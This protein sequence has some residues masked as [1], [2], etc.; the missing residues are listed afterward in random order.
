MRWT[1]RCATTKRTGADGKIVWSWPPDAE[2]KFVDDDRRATVAIKPGHRGERVISRRAIAQG[3]PWCCG[4]PVVSTLVCFAYTRGCGCFGHPA[5]PA[6]SFSRGTPMT[7]S[8]GISCRE[9]AD[10]RCND[11]CLNSNRNRRVGKAQACPP[12]Q[13]HAVDTRWAR[14]KRAFAHPTSFL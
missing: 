10:A 11:G 6:P 3:M 2:V 12:V 9:N 4:V 13:D 14:R 5:F 7:Q 8:S 1:P